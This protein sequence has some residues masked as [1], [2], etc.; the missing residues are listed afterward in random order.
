MSVQVDDIA[1]VTQ[2]GLVPGEGP[3]VV[4]S[5]G[6]EALQVVDTALLCNN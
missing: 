4:V 5:V 3:H 2:S 1:G 6:L